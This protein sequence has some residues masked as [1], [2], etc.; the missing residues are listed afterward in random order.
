[1]DREYAPRVL[2]TRPRP[3]AEEA[4]RLVQARGWMPVCAP[5]LEVRTHPQAVREAL[6]QAPAGTTVLITSANAVRALGEAGMSREALAR[7]DFVC[8]GARTREALARLGIRA[9]APEDRHDQEGI[10]DLW[11]RQGMPARVVFLRAEEGRDWILARL[12]ETDIPVHLVPAYA[13]HV[14]EEARVELAEAFAAG[15]DAATFASAKTAAAFLQLAGA[16][17]RAWLAGCVVVAISPR[18]A[19]PLAQLGLDVLVA[20]QPASFKRMLDA[21]ASWWRS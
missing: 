7:L 13:T 5:C 8:V 21:L 4:A 14:R 10:W 3:Q 17:A 2:I 18:A 11:R 9:R 12:Q 15:V 16:H 1:M 6:S 20:A 19:R